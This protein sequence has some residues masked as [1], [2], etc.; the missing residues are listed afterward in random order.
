MWMAADE[1]S[2]FK[3]PCCP[4]AGVQ[5]RAH[6]HTATDRKRAGA[7]RLRRFIVRKLRGQ[8]FRLCLLRR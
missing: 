5:P 1:I 6:P 7:R 8:S 2:R 3:R 4:V